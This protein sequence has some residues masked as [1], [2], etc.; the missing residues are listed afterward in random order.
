MSL[1]D[2]SIELLIKCNEAI[3]SDRNQHNSKEYDDDLMSNIKECL[4]HLKQNTMSIVY[5]TSEL[6]KMYYYDLIKGKFNKAKVNTNELFEP[7]FL[8]KLNQRIQFVFN[9]EPLKS[10]LQ[11]KG[12]YDPMLMELF[13]NDN[14]EADNQGLIDNCYVMLNDMIYSNSIPNKIKSSA[15]ILCLNQSKISN[16]PQS[17]YKQKVYLDNQNR[18]NANSNKNTLKPPMNNSKGIG[19]EFNVMSSENNKSLPKQQQDKSSV[20]T[21][22]NVIDCERKN[23]KGSSQCFDSIAN[24]KKS[25]KNESE[26]TFGIHQV[27]DDYIIYDEQAKNLPKLKNNNNTVV[28]QQKAEEKLC[29]EFY[30]GTLS[31]IEKDYNQY[32]NLIPI[33]QKNTFDL[34]SNLTLFSEAISPMLIVGYKNKSICSM[35]LLS[36]YSED[37]RIV[38]IKQISTIENNLNEV[39][40]KLM[41]F[42]QDNIMYKELVINLHFETKGDQYQLNKEL[43]DIFKGLNFKW[44][45]LEN[46]DN[47]KRI[48]TMKYRNMNLNS[49][50]NSADH[51]CY[52]KVGMIACENEGEYNEDPSLSN[53]NTHN[54]NILHKTV[55]DHLIKQT[56]KAS[57]IKNSFSNLIS[58]EGMKE[59]AI[60]YINER[61]NKESEV[62]FYLDS[63]QED[64]KL[65]LSCY[66]LYPMFQTLSTRTINQYIYNRLEIK[67][68]ILYEKETN[69]TFYMLQQDDYVI[70]LGQMA[71][72]FK[73]Y[74]DN[75]KNIYEGFNLLY[76]K[77]EVI[78]KDI[79][80]I[81][82]PSFSLNEV[83]SCS[84]SEEDVTIKSY[85]DACLGSNDYQGKTFNR[86]PM[87]TDEVISDAFFIAIISVNLLNSFDVSS[88]FCDIVNQNKWKSV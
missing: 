60:A 17:K 55:I 24:D 77:I 80:H 28:S 15:N 3:K 23:R 36:L 49:K 2:K 43:T 11:I 33:S 13:S 52:I 87:S 40:L 41:M 83:Y 37:Y 59:D 57:E 71:P 58:F 64:M 22:K 27:N 76:A 70:L 4:E 6:R 1:R 18:G 74:L 10:F 68:E 54:V 32:Y 47:G 7:Y 81:W 65:Y 73:T 45:K 79:K 67:N 72:G 56:G 50:N 78:Q 9:S 38:I 42:I 85:T 20:R 29:F 82:V 44:S 39:F 16:Q 19:D 51:L 26:R 5:A 75:S 34:Y 8:S 69:Q 30:T 25:E 21:D 35:C 62:I 63:I 86:E 88:I 66:T 61:E 12:Q 31:T 53:N 84:L 46:L 14:N 48:Q